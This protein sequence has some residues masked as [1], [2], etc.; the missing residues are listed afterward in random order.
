LVLILRTVRQT[1]FP[2]NPEIDEL[3]SASYTQTNFGTKNEFASK[4]EYG[5]GLLPHDAC[6]PNETACAPDPMT[7]PLPQHPALDSPANTQ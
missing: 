7:M 3:S 4:L 6:L 1:S 2:N 5:N